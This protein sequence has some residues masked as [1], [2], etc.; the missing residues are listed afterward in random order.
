M[1]WIA[2]IF[3]DPVWIVWWFYLLVIIKDIRISYGS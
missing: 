3:L 1:K 2:K